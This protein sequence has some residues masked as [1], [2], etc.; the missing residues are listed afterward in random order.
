MTVGNHHCYGRSSPKVTVIKVLC[1][2]RYKPFIPLHMVKQVLGG[3]R[4]IQQKRVNLLRYHGSDSMI[5]GVEV[6]KE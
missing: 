5:G 6:L 1:G 2:S 4:Q 3:V